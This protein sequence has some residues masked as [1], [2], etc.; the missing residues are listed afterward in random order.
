MAEAAQPYYI[1]MGKHKPAPSEMGHKGSCGCAAVRTC[2]YP[3][4]PSLPTPVETRGLEE[5]NS[6]F[7]QRPISVRSRP[8]SLSLESDQQR[9][10]LLRQD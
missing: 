6:G 9:R 5:L 3:H 4:L 2:P 1:I 10:L 8:S 7:G